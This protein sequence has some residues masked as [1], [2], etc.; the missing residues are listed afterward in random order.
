MNRKEARESHDLG[1]S[2]LA[3]EFR[4]FPKDK[5]PLAVTWRNCI[6]CSGYSTAEVERYE[7]KACPLWPYS[8]GTNPFWRVGGQG[9]PKRCRSSAPSWLC[10]S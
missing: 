1:I 9:P 6:Y 8:F 7:L 10:A 2:Q 3:R 4:Q 5:G